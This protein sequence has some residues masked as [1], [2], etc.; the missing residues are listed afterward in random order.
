MSD[1]EIMGFGSQDEW[2]R[3]NKDFPKFV[4]KYDALGDNARQDFS[5]SSSWRQD[6]ADYLWLRT[7]LL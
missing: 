3:F 7:R 5:A 6:G 1:E 4:E 2:A